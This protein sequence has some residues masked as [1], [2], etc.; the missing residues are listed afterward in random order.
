MRQL[1]HRRCD[2][3][4]IFVASSSVLILG[5]DDFSFSIT[6]SNAASS[7]QWLLFCC[8][9]RYLYRLPA[10]EITY[11]YV[12]LIGPGLRWWMAKKSQCAYQVDVL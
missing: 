11:L 6:S 10:C 3:F 5:Y 9:G 1:L 12:V 2:C 7:F 8:R 4:C